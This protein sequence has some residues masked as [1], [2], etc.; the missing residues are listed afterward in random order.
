MIYGSFYSEYSKKINLIINDR[1]LLFKPNAIY[2]LLLTEKFLMDDFRCTTVSCSMIFDT[3]W[4]LQ[5]H[6]KSCSGEE[7]VFTKQVVLG[8]PENDLE[9]AIR[10]GNESSQIKFK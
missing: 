8:S 10:L 7:L 4:E 1:D 2:S 9:Y 3:N 5:R 6:R